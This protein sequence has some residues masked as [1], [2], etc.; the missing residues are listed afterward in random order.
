MAE[1]AIPGAFASNVVVSSVSAFILYSFLPHNLIYTWLFLHII[2]FIGRIFISKK[3]LYFLKKSDSRKNIQQYLILSLTIT[4]LTAT[5]YAVIIWFIYIYNV[6]DL[7]VFL[8]TILI[9]VTVASSISTL[10]NI[11]IIFILFVSLSI[12]PLIILALF[13]G[14]EIFLMLALFL[15]IYIIMHILFGYRQ[16]IMLRNAAFLEETFQSSPSEQLIHHQ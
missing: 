10:G 8:M 1:S 11:I 9:L 6:P 2:L 5:L 12:I 15:F 14:G 16:Y 7:Y 3:L 4:S 13:H